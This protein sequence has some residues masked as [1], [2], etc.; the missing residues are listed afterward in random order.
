MQGLSGILA[1]AP[2]LAL[3]SDGT[4]WSWGD[5]TMFELGDGSYFASA[6]VPQQVAGLSGV[7]AISDFG[8]SL[9]P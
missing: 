4:V 8:Y 3:K 5:D 6:D 9:V 1:I 7:T 2:R